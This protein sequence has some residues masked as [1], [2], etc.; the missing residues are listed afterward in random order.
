MDALQ[1][2]VNPAAQSNA[3]GGASGHPASVLGLMGMQTR[4]NA[5]GTPEDKRKQLHEAAKEFEAVFINML[6]EGMRQTVPDD[7][8]LGGGF[9]GKTFQSMADVETS[10]S[11]AQRGGFG[12]ADA[13][14][15]QLERQAGLDRP[16]LN[17]N[18]SP[19]GAAGKPEGG[20]A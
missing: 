14:Y 8:M 13:V 4:L 5:A 16:A 17:V 20:A 11:M 6:M 2:A 3:A 15:R 12:I 7:P 18:S 19:K 1:P 9:A 10:R